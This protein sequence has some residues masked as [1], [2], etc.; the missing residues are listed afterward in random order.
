MDDMSDY[1]T[2]MTIVSYF[3]IVPSRQ[4]FLTLSI[5]VIGNVHCGTSCERIDC[6]FHSRSCWLLS[7]H[8]NSP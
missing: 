6:A 7:I 2:T 3:L 5:A 1:Y 4:L 8:C